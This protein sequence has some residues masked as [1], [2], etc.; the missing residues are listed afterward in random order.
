MEHDV[1]GVTTDVRELKAD[2]PTVLGST[3]MLFANGGDA[4]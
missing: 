4:N 3:R 1:A 2:M